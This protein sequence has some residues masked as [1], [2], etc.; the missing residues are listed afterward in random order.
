MVDEVALKGIEIGLGD[1]RA[2]EGGARHGERD[3]GGP[4]GEH[5]VETSGLG[6]VSQGLGDPGTPGRIDLGLAR[7]DRQGQGQVGVFRHADI[8]ADQHGGHGLQGDHRPR[9]GGAGRRDGD[10]QQDLVLIAIVHQGT[11]G[12]T[13][14]GGPDNVTGGEARR[15]GPVE[16]GRLAGVA[17][18]AP[19]GVPV[20]LDLLAQGDMNHTARRDP[21]AVGHQFGLD[22]PDLLGG[23]LGRQDQGK[24]KD[25]GDPGEK[26][27]HPKPH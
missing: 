24:S 5:G 16:T 20:L 9:P 2:L 1:I 13:A 22:V 19:I 3:P 27:C 6:R 18:I 26:T 4:H 23:R 25:R 8:G 11:G 14:G 10:R 12:V 7:G 21:A 15:Q 17:G